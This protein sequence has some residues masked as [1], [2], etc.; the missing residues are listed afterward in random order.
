[1]RGGVLL[2]ACAALVAGGWW[3][4]HRFQRVG[5]HERGFVLSHFQFDVLQ[6]WLRAAGRCDGRYGLKGVQHLFAVAGD[7]HRCEVLS[8]ALAAF[9]W[10]RLIPCRLADGMSLG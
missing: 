2:V 9:P 7:F 6:D 1:M 8:N 3:L 10:K 4:W 5:G